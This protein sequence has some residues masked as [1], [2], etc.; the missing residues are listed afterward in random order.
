MH[1]ADI[2]SN[3]QLSNARKLL[4]NASHSSLQWTPTDPSTLHVI[5]DTS[6]YWNIYELDT[7]SGTCPINHYEPCSSVHNTS[8]IQGR[9]G[10]N[11]YPTNTDIGGPFWVFANVRPYAISKSHMVVAVDGKLLHKSRVAGGSFQAIESANSAGFTVF[12]CLIITNDA[13]LYA[14]ASGPKRSASVVRVDMQQMEVKATT[15]CNLCG[16]V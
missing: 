12:S 2:G 4:D 13:L 8:H 5:S 10:E 6:G 11:L 3:G 1:I 7:N 16:F 14:I 15:S 9:L